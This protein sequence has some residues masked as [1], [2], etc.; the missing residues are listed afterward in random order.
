MNI[1]FGL[2]RQ[3]DAIRYTLKTDD[4]QT[5]YF[6]DVTKNKHEVKI[7]DKIT[8]LLRGGKKIYLIM[9]I[10]HSSPTKPFIEV[11]D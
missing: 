4:Y 7:S 6:H 2:V 5:I 3:V 8:K 1:G 10:D 9:G 11:I